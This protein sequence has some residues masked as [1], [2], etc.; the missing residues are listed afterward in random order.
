MQDAEGRVGASTAELACPLCATPDPAAYYQD[1]RRS[2]WRCGTCALV[3]VP[4]EFWPTAETEKARY[5]AHRNDPND[6]A[7]RRFLSRLA[8]PVLE[9]VPEGAEGLDFGCGPGPAL[10]AMLRERGHRVALYDP[11]YAP[12]ESVWTRSYDFVTAS[13]VVEH[14]K[15]PARELERVFGVLRPGGWLGVM[16]QP[17][18]EASALADWHYL[19]D[20]TH[21]CFYSP[22]T[23]QYVA[24][25]WRARIVSPTPDVILFQAGRPSRGIA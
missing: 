21:V 5:D 8:D 9:R 23:F 18:R 25:R 3:F 11:F 12:D 22:R 10:A 13:E 4:P 15:H 20:F 17:I 1:R 16:T 2:Y 14:L 24:A 7:Y 19:R 6:P